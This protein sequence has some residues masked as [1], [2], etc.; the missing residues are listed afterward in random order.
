MDDIK[1]IQK[2]LKQENTPIKEKKIIK[3]FNGTLVLL[4]VALAGLI[5][6]KQDEDGTLLKRLFNID[7]SFKEMNQTIEN[8]LNNVFSIDKEDKNDDLTVSAIDIYHSL[9]SNNYSSD[10]KTIRMLT[11]GE[12][13]VSSFQNEYKYFVAVKYSNGVS[14]LYTLIDEITFT[15]TKL[16]KNDVIG[17]YTG[18]YFS[19]IFKKGDV[20]ISYNEAIK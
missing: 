3:F 7:V 17:S 20:T 16:E 10:D 8:T 18:D 5:Y 13:I 6:C 15:N 12:I 1:R 14:A 4:L 19:C 11:D 9:G 2:R